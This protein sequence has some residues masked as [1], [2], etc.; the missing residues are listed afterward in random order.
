MKAVALG[1]AALV[2]LMALAGCGKHGRDAPADGRVT[3]RFVGWGAPEERAVFAE[4]LA[5]LEHERPS[6][7]VVYTQV[8]G[9]GY[10][11]LNKLR[12]MIVAGMAPDVFYVPDGAFPELVRSG[13]LLDL[14]PYVRASTVID[15]GAIWPTAI[16]RYRW[17]GE[18]L[19][20]GDLHALP[21]DL[22][23]MVM[24][25]NLALLRLRGVPAPRHDAPL[26]WAE[27]IAMWRA[28]TFE[29]GGIQRWG[30]T[31]FPYDAAVWSSGGEILSPDRRSWLLTTPV[32]TRAVQWCADLALREGV[33][34][35][36]ARLGPE[37]AQGSE[38]FEAG[39]AATHID[40]RWMVPRY[41]RLSFDWD[42]ALV[43]SPERGAPSIARS[44]SVGL[45]VSAKS[46]HPA[47]AFAV[48]EFLAGPRGQA[49]LTETGFQL[50]NQRAL[51]RT[52]TFLQPGRRPAHAEVFI[53]AAETSRPGPATLTPTAFWHDV[54]GTYVDAVW[55]G[56]RTAADL[57]PE[58]RPRIEQALRSSATGAADARGDVRGAR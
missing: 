3:I 16:D 24:F 51:A 1:A 17:S 37:A 6:I 36:P 5:E 28:L 27:A 4:A 56:D 31:G 53:A 9:V 54:F 25:Y 44:G 34:P 48:V 32:G 18:R 11:Y 35:N 39:L 40:G 41:R 45:G 33:A 26:T 23:P 8:P 47:E 12:L 29:Q 49:K 13:T 7:R 46:A 52:D 2:G 57:F 21:K 42:V 14:E 58:I 43:P 38:L 50:P 20:E 55:R 15:V 10:D 22:G 19:H 30:L